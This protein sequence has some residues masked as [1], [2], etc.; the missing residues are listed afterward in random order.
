MIF[1]IA[2]RRITDR[3][4]AG[5]G[6]R[7]DTDRC[8]VQTPRPAAATGPAT[9]PAP[10]PWRRELAEVYRA[11]ADFVLR[12]AAH[13]G[14]PDHHLDDVVH[15]VFLV[16][17]RRLPDFDGARGSLRSWLF[18]ITRHV[19]L[20]H[21]RAAARHQR[22]LTI[23]PTPPRQPRPDEEVARRRVI[24]HI[25]TFLQS[26]PPRKR[27]VFALAD[28]EGMPA[29]EV[30]R[31]LGTNVNTIYARLRSARQA[32]AGYLDQLERDREGRREGED[33]DAPA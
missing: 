6:E 3:G 20:H 13:L 22:K 17:H 4:R 10:D 27:I 18:G 30:A 24:D 23:V 11:H 2:W 7:M 25:E 5:K 21:R 1:T 33:H 16:A 31:S 15:D 19:V 26:L 8:G 29:V 32:F 28:L 14:V 12:C 9:V